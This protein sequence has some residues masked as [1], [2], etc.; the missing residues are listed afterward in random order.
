M[1]T[2]SESTL[3]NAALEAGLF[4]RNL[5]NRQ[6]VHAR[7]ARLSLLDALSRELGLPR[8]AF[9]L[10]LA[11]TNGLPYAR[12]DRWQLD[13]AAAGRLPGTLIKRHP[14]APMRTPEGLSLIHI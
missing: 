11:Q 13:M 9:F 6:R 4:D 5:L 3:I 2:I 1:S 10:E 8:T 14:M 7:T 12:L